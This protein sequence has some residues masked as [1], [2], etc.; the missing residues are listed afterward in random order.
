MLHTRG[1]VR[2]RV[3]RTLEGDVA[4]EAPGRRYT[5]PNPLALMAT[6]MLVTSRASS[7]SQWHVRSLFT[8][9]GS[10][11]LLLQLKRK[12]RGRCSVHEKDA[13]ANP[14]RN[15]RGAL[16]RS[17]L[18]GKQPLKRLSVLF[19]NRQQYFCPYLNVSML[20]RGEIIL[21][22]PNPLG[23]DL[24]SRIKSPQLTNSAADCFPVDD[25]RPVTHFSP[26]VVARMSTEPALVYIGIPHRILIKVNAPGAPGVC[27]QGKLR[28]R[29]ALGFPEPGGPSTA[30]YGA[31][32]SFS[33]NQ[34]LNTKAVNAAAL[35]QGRGRPPNGL[36]RSKSATSIYTKRLRSQPSH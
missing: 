15:D 7:R 19:A 14:P 5:S 11:E 36:A 6:R 34:L 33:G 35:E 12:S 20:H 4:T 26:W 22:H 24:L 29:N 27:L 17:P 2:G 13:Q 3:S 1:L 28:M 32:G 8:E 31:N 18:S 10:V 9:Q 21:A 25:D 30:R 23:E 16:S